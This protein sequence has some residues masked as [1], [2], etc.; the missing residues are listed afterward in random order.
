[1]RWCGWQGAVSEDL[2][3]GSASSCA[4]R[5]AGGASGCCR[6]SC[7]DVGIRTGKDRA[8]PGYLLCRTFLLCFFCLPLCS[9]N[10]WEL[11][12]PDISLSSVWIILYSA[13]FSFASP[14][15][16]VW[17]SPLLAIYPTIDGLSSGKAFPRCLPVSS[18]FLQMFFSRPQIRCRCPAPTDQRF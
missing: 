12:L 4:F 15:A 18:I 17:I 14:A 3:S 5:R 2:E 9:L 13:F 7:R 1:M 8:V 11:V 6:A 16:L 10:Q